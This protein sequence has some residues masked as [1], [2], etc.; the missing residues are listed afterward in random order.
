MLQVGSQVVY[1]VHGVC[2]IIG[3]EVRTVDRKNVE[4]FI[5]QPN[6]QRGA[7][8]YVPAH[9]QAALSKL[10]PLLTKT[11]LESLLESCEAIQDCWIPVEN[12][13]KQRYKELINSADFA[14]II[15]MIR[16]AH[17]HREE[18]LAA[19]RKFHL[20]DEN[21]LR[22]AKKLLASECSVVLGIPLAD[23]SAYLNNKLM[24]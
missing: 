18:Q 5:L 19:G 1:G 17:H 11:E 2:N 23:V 24:K 13:R 9:N 12:L 8:F 14:A 3:T 6:D 7:Q 10:R 22:D 15:N 4:Y 20:C 16:L 21:F